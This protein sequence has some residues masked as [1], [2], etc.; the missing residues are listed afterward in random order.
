[1]P[2]PRAPSSNSLYRFPPDLLILSGI[3]IAAVALLSGIVLDLLPFSAD[4][5]PTFLSVGVAIFILSI[6]ILFVGH[7]IAALFSTS[8][9]IRIKKYRWLE[10]LWAIASFLVFLSLFIPSRGYPTSRQMRNMKTLNEL[11]QV[12]TAIQSYETEYGSLPTISNNRDLVRI[13]EGQNLES[14]NPRNIEFISLH[15][16]DFDN[17]GNL[18]DA[19]G[20]PLRI[21]FLDPKNP[22]VWSAG[23]DQIWS[24]PDDLTSNA[25]P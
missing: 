11:T 3:P 7:G 8:L 17:Q 12:S 4:G 10:T 13:L 22:K 23:A 2:I 6:P 16:R 5:W 20:T 19:W 14:Q 9:R 25:F 18:I 15:S 21:S 1:M 24:T